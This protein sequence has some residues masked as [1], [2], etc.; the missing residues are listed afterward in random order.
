VFAAEAMTIDHASGGRLELSYGA[1]WF[2]QEH[3]QL[4][5]PFPDLK[6]RVDGF[7]EAV[8]IVRGLLT[9]DDFSFEGKHFSVEHATLLPRPV[10]SPHPPI[11]IG[12]SGERRM[13]PIAARYADVWHCFGNVEQLSEK[14]RRLS[15][16]AEGAGRD[17]ATIMR[18]AS[19]SLE[20]DADTITRNVD[21]WRD[22][23]FGYLVCGWP[24]GG[25]AT[26][27]EFAAR[28]LG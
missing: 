4:G 27:E 1:A 26:I 17:P 18:A 12:A 28:H 2:D 24:A 10:Q 23:G 16:M 21:A 9:T 22:A 3:R 14:S 8:Q 13:M 11:W 19:L 25:R 20:D 6:D 7:E 15:A 5:I